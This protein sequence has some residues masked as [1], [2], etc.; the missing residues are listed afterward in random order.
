MEPGPISI[1]ADGT[2]EEMGRLGDELDAFN[3]AATGVADE[4]PLRLV[5]R[6][7]AGKM[8]AGLKAVTGWGWLYV[9]VLWVEEGKRGKGL[10]TKLMDMAEREAMGRGC[11]NACLSS[12]SFQAPEFY[13]RRGYE[14]FGELGDYPRGETMY[15][16]RKRLV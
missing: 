14:V 13:R 7:G 9:I 3:A 11:G 4:R 15:F 8:V 2:A 6:D 10:G 1:S 5:A 12:F 16:L